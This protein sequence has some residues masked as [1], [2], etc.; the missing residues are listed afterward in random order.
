MERIDYSSW[1]RLSLS[2][3][4]L[5]LDKSNPRIPS[6]VIT[7]T[8]KDIL[9]YLFESEKIDRLAEK[10]VDK[11]FIS[12]DP[13]YAVKEGDNYVIV[14]GNRR[15]SALKCLL[16]P[17]L[18]PS[19]I[20]KRKM[21]ILKNRMGTDLIEKIDVIVAPSRRDVEN[22]L[23]ELH[24]EGKLQ[25]NRQQKN[26]FIAGIGIDGGDSIVEIAQRFNVKVSE[27]EES[28]Q[29]YIIERYFTEIDLPTD[30]EDK[31]LKTKFNIS[32]ISRLLNANKF[33]LLTGFKVDENKIV[34]TCSKTL[35]DSLLRRF[36]I[37]I[38]NK[39]INSRT[40]NTGD[41]INKYIDFVLNDIPDVNVQEGEKVSFSPSKS[42]K[43][44]K[45]GSEQ[46]KI[47]IKK[48]KETLILKDA[49]YFT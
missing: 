26:K 38:V 13:I 19:T 6:Y 47:I 11:G 48:R 18:A 27:I 14:E 34:T 35:F 21:D 33:R 29:E 44:T 10:I 30:I 31:A 15:V 40:I 5:R 17:S 4:N 24:A 32:T 16:D 9:N 42:G 22:V 7:R 23:F 49:E 3:A 20:K 28:V 39:T 2:V 43:D 36:V 37:D 8:T 25:W 46:P 12:H 1:Q 45:T 41:E